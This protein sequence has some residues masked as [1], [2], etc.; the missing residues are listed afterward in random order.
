MALTVNYTISPATVAATLYRSTGS[1]INLLNLPTDKVV[2]DKQKNSFTYNDGVNNTHYSFVVETVDANGRKNYSVIEDVIYKKEVGPGSP[3]ITRGYFDFGVYG[4]V[5]SEELGITPDGARDYINSIAGNTPPLDGVD[6][7]NIWYK[8]LVNKRIIFIPKNRMFYMGVTSAYSQAT[9]YKT[10]LCDENGLVDNCPTMMLK[11]REYKWRSLCHHNTDLTG[12]AA[13][14][15]IKDIG[16]E[17]GRKL[18]TEMGMYLCLTRSTIWLAG[19]DKDGLGLP[20]ESSA[21][22][23]PFRGGWNAPLGENTAI[24]ACGLGTHVWPLVGGVCFVH[25]TQ[26]PTLGVQGLSDYPPNLVAQIP[27]LELLD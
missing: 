8:C 16:V 9:L 25:M 4:E 23:A 1:K 26:T 11:G 19:T 3:K 22:Q 2:L 7:T 18:R 14:A 21:T 17:N 24:K 20:T 13:L 27:V 6:T 5:T 10:R 15:A 12:A